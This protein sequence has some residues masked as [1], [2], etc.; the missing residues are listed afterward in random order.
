LAGGGQPFQMFNAGLR[1]ARRHCGGSGSV[2][3]KL[4]VAGCGLVANELLRKLETTP[5]AA[6]PVLAK[7]ESLVL[8]SYEDDSP[9]QACEEK[10]L[11]DTLQG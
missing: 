7:L 6:L 9:V 2:L 3:R 10:M 8:L 1:L 11:M 4:N 5:D